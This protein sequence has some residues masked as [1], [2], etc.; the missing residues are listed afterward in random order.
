MILS[1]I[2]IQRAIDEGRLRIIPDPQPRNP[3]TPNCPYN[4]TAVDLHPALHSQFRKR[5][6]LTTI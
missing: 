2:E 4:T 3:E 5:G 6:R 1:N